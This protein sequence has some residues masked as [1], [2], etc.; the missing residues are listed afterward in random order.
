[1][2]LY[3]SQDIYDE[4]EILVEQALAS[5]SKNQ[6]KSYIDRLDFLRRCGNYG[7]YT[8]IVFSELVAS[9]QCA[10]GRVSDKER[11]CG[12]ARQSLYKLQGQ[13]D[14]KGDES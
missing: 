3:I 9:V 13:I 4:I 14:K 7:G 12:F 8:N 5:S 2:N 11:L 6:A 10:S 1:M